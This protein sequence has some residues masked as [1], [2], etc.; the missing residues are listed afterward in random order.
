[1]YLILV[2]EKRHLILSLQFLVLFYH[3]KGKKFTKLVFIVKKTSKYLVNISEF[4]FF[5]NFGFLGEP[6]S[7]T[8]FLNSNTNT[9]FDLYNLVNEKL[10]LPINI[11]YGLFPLVNLAE[12]FFFFLHYRSKILCFWC[13]RIKVL[14][15]LLN[16][17]HFCIAI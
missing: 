8:T 15:L 4:L 7:K 10:S 3:K 5:H 17:Q 6:F 12:F 13:Y 2:L 11:L 9:N 14:I 16:E 1:M